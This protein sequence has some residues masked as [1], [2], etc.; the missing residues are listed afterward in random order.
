VGDK[1]TI[2]LLFDGGPLH[3]A[4]VE[5]TFAGYADGKALAFSSRT[6]KE[7]RFVFIPLK[8]GFWMLKAFHELPYKD[9]TVCDIDRYEASIT[10]SIP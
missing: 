3:N 10:F 8:E 9:S 7:G 6:D 5:G 2:V 4:R 1:L